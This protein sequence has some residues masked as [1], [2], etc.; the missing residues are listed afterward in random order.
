MRLNLESGSAFEEFINRSIIRDVP[1]CLLE[2]YG[3]LRDRARNV[4]IKTKVILTA[5]DHWA[6]ANAKAWMAE[7]TNKGTKLVIVEHGGSLAT[8]RTCFDFEEDISDVKC[9]WFLPHHV[10]H[11]RLPPAKLVIPGKKYSGTS[12]KL[13]LRKYCSVIGTE[14]QRWVL[15]AHFYPMAAQCLVSV[16]LVTRL[17]EKLGD[18]VR[19]AFRVKPYPQNLGWNTW[20]R[21]SDILGPE[22]IHSEKKI[23][24]V[25][26]LSKLIVCT[27]PET[28]FSQAMASGVPTILMYPEYL[29]EFN[30]IAL[31]LL[32]S[33]KAAK[34]VFHDPVAAADHLNAI[35]VD[36]NQWWSSP[37]V[38]Y[39]RSEFYRQ[40]LDMDRKWLKKWATFLRG[41]VAP[42]TEKTAIMNNDHFH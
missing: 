24:R 1:R 20:Q 16:E 9:T 33:L 8:Y 6:N 38:L 37:A 32:E 28:T 31:P 36:P 18:E 7:Q 14:Q 5:N 19:R 2:S 3:A 35:W 25:F 27:Y 15:R 29:Y 10:K 34:I 11:R 17:Y 39:A 41:V 42:E 30:P 21:Y 12:N 26:G 13:H 23:D 4:S 22:H 40:A